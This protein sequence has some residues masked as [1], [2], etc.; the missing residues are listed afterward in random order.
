MSAS[1]RTAG[2]SGAAVAA[3]IGRDRVIAGVGE[4]GQLMAP[5]IPALREAVQQQYQRTLAGLGD[6]HAQAAGLD[7]AVRN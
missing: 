2:W 1:R 5:G 6:V 3:L 7:I 4:C